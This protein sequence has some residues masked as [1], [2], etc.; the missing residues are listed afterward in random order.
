ML[1]SLWTNVEL[2]P[3]VF[4]VPHER[5]YFMYVLGFINHCHAAKVLIV[6]LW[7][8]ICNLCA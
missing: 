5:C 2:T 4:L 3:L 1:I 8:L 7:Y 6:S